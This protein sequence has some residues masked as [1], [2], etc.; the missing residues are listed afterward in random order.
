M[1]NLSLKTLRSFKPALAAVVMMSLAGSPA[2]AG[3]PDRGN[4]NPGILPP[5]S[6]PFGKSYG[7]WSD[8]WVQWA[9]SIPADQNPIA[10]T[11]GQFAGM[12]QS[13]KVWFLAGTF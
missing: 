12:G 13:G 3:G 5:S 4:P 9:Y 7:A 10:D 1:K 6:N 11:T 2:F 8:A